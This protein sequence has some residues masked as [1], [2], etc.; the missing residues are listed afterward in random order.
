M[1]IRFIIILLAVSTGICV[2]SA[3]G[4]PDSKKSDASNQHETTIVVV[5]YNNHDSISDYLYSL[6]YLYDNE[7][8]NN[9][10]EYPSLDHLQYLYFVEQKGIYHSGLLID[11]V[12][13]KVICDSHST[14]ITHYPKNPEILRDLNEQDISNIKELSEKQDITNWKFSYDGTG[15]ESYSDGNWEGFWIISLAFD[16]GSIFQTSGKGNYDT[17]WPDKYFELKDALFTLAE[18]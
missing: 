15:G 10:S 4:N 12:N 7:K 14:L 6:Y 17:G 8:N 1:K 16:D 9:S 11:Y 18:N 5:D 3:C 2:F 13:N